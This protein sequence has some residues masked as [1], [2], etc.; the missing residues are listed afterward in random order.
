MRVRVRVLVN[1]TSFARDHMNCCEK[2][3]SRSVSVRG[4]DGTCLA[5]H[6]CQKYHAPYLPGTRNINA[7]HNLYLTTVLIVQTINNINNGIRT[8]QVSGYPQPKI[9]LCAHR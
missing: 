7:S 6:F 8:W 5:S 3:A 4:R 9:A 2:S 1:F